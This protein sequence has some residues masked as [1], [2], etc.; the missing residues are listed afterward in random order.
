LLCYTQSG[1]DRISEPNK[2]A[3][4]RNELILF[5]FRQDSLSLW[6]SHSYSALDECGEIENENIK[7]FDS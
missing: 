5:C 6:D 4:H 3:K 7:K 2:Y 1:D